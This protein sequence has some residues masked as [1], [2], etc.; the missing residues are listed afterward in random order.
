M[1]SRGPQSRARRDRS[2]RFTR[3]QPTPSPKYLI[4][5]MYFNQ[6]SSNYSNTHHQRSSGVGADVV[7]CT[8]CNIGRGR[9]DR[10]YIRRSDWIPHRRLVPT[11]NI[12][13]LDAD[14]G[15]LDE[16]EHMDV[17]DLASS[18]STMSLSRRRSSAPWTPMMA[19]RSASRS[20]QKTKHKCPQRML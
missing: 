1:N 18:V 7:D 20:T 9:K 11:D 3:I 15:S 14:D 19:P 16:L 17:D 13:P 6:F 4:F 2:R 12:A 8:L 10:Y 5:L